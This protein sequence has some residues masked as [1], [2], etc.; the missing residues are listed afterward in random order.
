[1]QLLP[2]SKLNVPK[3]MLLLKATVFAALMGSALGLPQSINLSNPFK[4]QTGTPICT[5]SS[6]TKPT[7]KGGIQT[8]KYVQI[9]V[10][11]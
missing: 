2:I 10:S 5:S 8:C 1:M 7:G 6:G 4:R 9:S 3:T 11:L